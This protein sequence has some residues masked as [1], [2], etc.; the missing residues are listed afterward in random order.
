MRAIYRHIP[1]KCRIPAYGL[2]GVLRVTICGLSGMRDAVSTATGKSVAVVIYI[3]FQPTL[4]VARMAAKT[5]T[6]GRMAKGNDSAK[7]RGRV[8]LGCAAAVQFMRTRRWEAHIDVCLEEGGMNNKRVG[9]R[10]RGMFVGSGG[11]IMP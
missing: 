1:A 4:H 2:H 10:P 8:R 9:G 3:F 7:A 6:K 5:V 11:T